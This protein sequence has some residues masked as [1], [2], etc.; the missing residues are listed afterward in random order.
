MVGGVFDLAKNGGDDFAPGVEKA[1]IGRG[2]VVLDRGVK[3]RQRMVG[4][5]RE[6]VMLHM[7]VHVPVEIPVD[8]VHVDRPAVEPVIE[9]IFGQA[10]MLG[11]AVDDHEPGAEEIGQ[12]DEQQ[13]QDAAR[14]DGKGDDGGVDGDVDAGLAIDLREFALRDEGLLL[15]RSCGR[16]SGAGCA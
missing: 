3:P 4:H 2:A 11:Q 13:R 8:R 7:V 1:G 15:G 14:A 16:R 5:Q 10:G 9:N 12:A 6:H